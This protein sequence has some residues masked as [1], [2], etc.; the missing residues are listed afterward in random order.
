MKR[1][2]LTATVV[3]AAAACETK[4]NNTELCREVYTAWCEQAFE[5]EEIEALHACIAYYHEDCRVRRLH[6]G[7]DEPS[8]EAVATCVAAISSMGCEVP[9]PS[10][11]PECPFLVQP[12]ADAGVDGGDGDTDGDADTDADGD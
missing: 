1:L 11:L 6:R 3:L 8:D 7:V 4:P 5:C 10:R 2:F 9:D 12:E